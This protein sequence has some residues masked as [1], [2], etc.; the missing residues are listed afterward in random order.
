VTGLSVPA[1]T[2]HRLGNG[3]ASFAGE[4]VWTKK[5]ETYDPSALNESDRALRLTTPHPSRAFRDMAAPARD[6]PLTDLP[7][8]ES[9]PSAL[10]GRDG[11]IEPLRIA[12]RN[13]T[14]AFELK[15]LQALLSRSGGSISRAAAISKVSRQMLQKLM[16]KHGVAMPRRSPVH[17]ALER[18]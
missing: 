1:G 6:G 2:S 16:R 18:E 13:A 3:A 10:N 15:Y 8:A 14:N 7:A 11:E 9:A 12:R 17:A 4:L 5:M